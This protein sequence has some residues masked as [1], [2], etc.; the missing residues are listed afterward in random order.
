MNF[1]DSKNENHALESWQDVS[2]TVLR[3]GSNYLNS[4]SG[5]KN[6]YYINNKIRVCEKDLQLLCKIKSLQH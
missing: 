1:E 6:I 4:A 2:A 5:F 3:H